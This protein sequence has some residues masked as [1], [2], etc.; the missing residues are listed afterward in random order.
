[1]TFTRTSAAGTCA[2]GIF[3][4]EVSVATLSRP[5]IFVLASCLALLLTG[6]APAHADSRCDPASIGCLPSLGEHGAV[7]STAT[8]PQAAG[9]DPKAAQLDSKRDL[10]PARADDRHDVRLADPM[11]L[12]KRDPALS[13]WVAQRA[14]A[15]ALCRVEIARARRVPAPSLPEE[16]VHLR[17]WIG[18]DGR[19]S[20]STVSGTG[21][22]GPKFLS[23]IK[24]EVAA[25]SMKPSDGS[26]VG[27]VDVN[28]R[29]PKRGP[30][31]VQPA[32]RGASAAALAWTD[33]AD[34]R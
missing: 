24:R 34:R 14:A 5:W 10:A 32:D 9:I 11:P 1:M 29:L 12:G 25:W 33:R 23:C 31:D 15:L 13:S 16:L 20:S 3:V 8:L 27:L 19:V 30:I 2:P 7:A 26:R 4:G 17:V 22:L 18:R 28:V 21:A 6:G